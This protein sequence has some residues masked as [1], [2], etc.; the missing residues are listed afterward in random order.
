[1]KTPTIFF[2]VLLAPLSRLSAQIPV[3]DAANLQQSISQYA[4]LVEQLSNQAT[5]I[6]NQM[7][8]IR[9]FET[10]L[11]RMGDM[12]A[13]KDLVGFPELKIEMTL[14]TKIQTWADGLARIDGYGLFGDTR[15]GVFRAVDAE[16]R[17][18]DGRVVQ[19]KAEPYKWAHE[20]AAKVNNFKDV[21]NDVYTRRERLREAIARTGEAVR[22]APTDAEAQKQ[23]AVL[24]AQ[25]N[26][27]TALDSEVTLSAAEIQV[28]AA[29][30]SAMADAQDEADAEA[31]K[32]LAQ[33]ETGKLRT[34]FK[35]TYE[36]MLQYVEERRIS[37]SPSNR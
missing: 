36:C 24:S 20:V 32:R 12:A 16:F 31:R 17:D 5:Q 28:K 1:M 29:E 2:V 22:L 34:A 3:T 23:E 11:T 4:A 7:E 9:Q 25:Y 8:Q 14:P 37:N 27:L 13:V 6:S 30:A 15:G 35:P 26:Q 33:Q 10:E 19:R 21:Q 18:F